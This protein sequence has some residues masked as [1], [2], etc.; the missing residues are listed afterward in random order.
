MK[1]NA[2]PSLRLT[3]GL[4]SIL[5]VAATFQAERRRTPYERMRLV[6]IIS[7]LCVPEIIYQPQLEKEKRVSLFGAVNSIA[8]IL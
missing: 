8:I 7:Y 3:H 5:C 2:D 6:R 4:G 1:Y